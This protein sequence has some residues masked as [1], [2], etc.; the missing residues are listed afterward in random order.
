[1]RHCWFLRRCSPTLDPPATTGSP[2]GSGTHS[3]SGRRSDGTGNRESA[4]FYVIGR[5]PRGLPR[6]TNPKARAPT[7]VSIVDAP[8]PMLPEERIEET[9]ERWT[10]PMRRRVLILLPLGIAATAWAQVVG[11]GHG[12]IG[13]FQQKSVSW[14][15]D[16]GNT[17]TAEYTTTPQP[18]H[19]SSLWQESAWRCGYTSCPGHRMPFDPAN[20]SSG[21]SGCRS[22]SRYRHSCQSSPYRAASARWWGA[23]NR[24]EA[25]LLRPSSPPR[26]RWCATDGGRSH[27]SGGLLA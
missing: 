20:G 23:S 18:T 15:V 27:R 7:S 16:C 19:C 26:S 8:V 12:P 22:Y 10:E 4:G 5:R 3:P 14:Q 6:H 2:P 21:H 1:M 11:F 13:M 25:P 9:M 24:R 17:C